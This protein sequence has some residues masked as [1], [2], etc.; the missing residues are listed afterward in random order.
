MKNTKN[1][2][3]FHSD[4]KQ[5]LA[6]IFFKTASR[7]NFLLYD[8]GNEDQN[9]TNLFA[10]EKTANAMNSSDIWLI[11]STFYISLKEFHRL[12]VNH[13]LYFRIRVPDFYALMKK[14]VSQHIKK[15]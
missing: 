3:T 5:R 6:F 11:D 12:F 1:E 9:R 13:A 15:Y 8:S 7:E 10:T 4:F 14:R 2:F